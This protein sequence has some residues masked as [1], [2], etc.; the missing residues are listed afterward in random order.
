M[1]V[2]ICRTVTALA[3]CGLGT[4]PA[5]ALSPELEALVDGN[6]RF[7]FD[8]YGELA[9]SR[10]GENVF[11]SP[12]SVSTALGMTYA[13]ARG[14]TAVEMADVLR[15]PSL[16][17]GVHPTYGELLTDLGSPERTDY[18]L[19]VANRLWGQDGFPLK[20]SFLGVTRDEY[21]AELGTVDFIGQTETART[22]INDWVADQTNDRILNLLPPGSVNTDTRL[23]LTNA[24][25]F[26]GDWQQPF[27]ADATY[28]GRF[29]VS[30]TEQIDARMMHQT[31]SFR[32][33]R[34]D[35]AQVLE[36]PYKGDDVSMLLV[37]PDD[38]AGIVAAEEWLNPET[39]SETIDALEIT[40]VDVKLPKFQMD[41]HASLSQSL[42]D[43]GMTSAFVPGGAD[44]TGIADADLFISDVIHK[45]FLRVDEKGTEAAAATG[46]VIGVTSLPPPP[47]AFFHADHP[48][49]LALRD[50]RTES[51]LFLGRVMRPE[52]IEDD[53]G[54]S[55]AEAT[56]LDGDLDGNGRVDQGDLDMVLSNWGA[57]PS[58]EMP[59]LHLVGT[60]DQN[61]LDA[62]LG[63]WGATAEAL[64][65]AAV[66]E[67]ATWL[68]LGLAAALWSPMARH[69]L[70]F[71]R[72]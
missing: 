37:L 4:L 53:A 49:L 16:D 39:L 7:A 43:L 1:R 68:L 21:G 45:S 6:N 70:G 54:G 48:F 35:D 19:A 59:I 63:N 17:A 40:R 14:Q 30:P 62:V 12:F 69:R 58:S 27:D 55:A 18:E 51:L 44:F 24:I 72:V 31:G 60:F 33:A 42:Q 36:M 9:A 64:Q 25:Y 61:D 34:L 2:A 8:L 28:D 41:M 23:V 50:N 22:L 65:A 3:L 67:P 56:P 47:S 5:A 20:Q 32:H 13:G 38:P 29:N 71:P 46:V 15:F 66:P 11:F 52:A 26:L 10:P 57:Q